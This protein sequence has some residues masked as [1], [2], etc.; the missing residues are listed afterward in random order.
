MTQARRS[1]PSDCS[2]LESDA[3]RDVSTVATFARAAT[4]PL[5]G[6]V[7]RMGPGCRPSAT[8]SDRDRGFALGRSVDAG[9][10]P[11]ANRA[12]AKDAAAASVHGAARVSRPMETAGASHANHAQPA[13]FAQRAHDGG[14]GSGTQGFVK[15]D[16]RLLRASNGAARGKVPSIRTSLVVNTSARWINLT[17]DRPQ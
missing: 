16:Y 14:A 10:D 8:V 17:C 9:A 13:D 6:H 15:R 7:S 12:G 2:A 4:P 11:I 3:A 1:Y 5:A